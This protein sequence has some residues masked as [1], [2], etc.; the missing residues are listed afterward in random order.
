MKKRFSM[1]FGILAVLFISQSAWA[2]AGDKTTTTTYWANGDLNYINNGAFVRTA[3]NGFATFTIA[4]GDNDLSYTNTYHSGW[5]SREARLVF[6]KCE[7]SQQKNYMLTWTKQGTGFQFDATGVRMVIAQVGSA[8]RFALGDEDEVIT[9]NGAGSKASVAT[10]KMTNYKDGMKFY[11]RRGSWVGPLPAVGEYCLMT[12]FEVNYEIIPDAPTWTKASDNMDVTVDNVLGQKYYDLS[13]N[14]N[15]ANPA[16]AGTVKYELVSNNAEYVFWNGEHTGFY[17]LKPGTYKVKAYIEKVDN[18]Y[19][20]SAYST[21]FTITAAT[22][23]A[24]KKDAQVYFVFDNQLVDPEDALNKIYKVNLPYTSTDEH[25]IEYISATPE[26]VKITKKTEN[27]LTYLG[28]TEDL[29]DHFTLNHKS[30]QDTVYV[31]QNGITYRLVIVSTTMGTNHLPYTITETDQFTN[32]TIV[33]YTNK[34]T[35]NDAYNDIEFDEVGAFETEKTRTIEFA[36]TGI[37]DSIK[38]SYNTLADANR[39]NVRLK[40]S[41]ATTPGN[42]IELAQVTAPQSTTADKNCAYA[43]PANAKYVQVQYYNAQYKGWVRNFTITEKK[44]ITFPQDTLVIKGTHTPGGMATKSTSLNWYNV[45]D[46]LNWG[47]GMADAAKFAVQ[48]SKIP[49]ALDQY[50]ENIPYNV[51]YKLDEPGIHYASIM[52]WS[53]DKNDKGEF[54]TIAYYTVKGITAYGEKEIVVDN[55]L[56]EDTIPATPGEV[57]PNPFVVKDSAGNELPADLKDSV[58]YEYTV[59]P[60]ES[61]TIDKDGNITPNCVGVVR[62]IAALQPNSILPAAF[63]TIYL[64]VPEASKNVIKWALPKTINKGDILP[65]A[66]ASTEDEAEMTYEF[67]PATAVQAVTGGYEVLQAGAFQIV[68]KAA[69]TCAHFAINDTVDVYANGLVA[70]IELNS[71]VDPA[72][73]SVLDTIANMFVVKGENGDTLA[74]PEANITYAIEPASMHLDED[75][76]FI[77]DHCGNVKV[78]VTVTGD[79]LKTATKDFTFTLNPIAEKI[80]SN[81]PDTLLVGKT[82]DLKNDLTST[83]SKLGIDTV[84]VPESYENFFTI[85]GTTIETLKKGVVRIIMIAKGNADFIGPI[86]YTKEVTIV[87][88]VKDIDWEKELKEELENPQVGDTIPTSQVKVFDEDGHEITGVEKTYEIIPEGAAHVTPEGDVVV[89]L[90]IDPITVVVTTEKEGMETKVDTIIISAKPAS[91]GEVELPEDLLD[92]DVHVGDTISLKDVKVY[93]Q[94][95]KDIT[96]QMDK[97][98]F[99]IEPED[100]AHFEKVGKNDSVLVIDKDE[101]FQIITKIT[102]PM[103]DPEH[104]TDT[105]KVEVETYN[106]GEVVM[107]EDVQKGELQPGETINTDDIRVLDKDGKDITDLCDKT[108]TFVPADAAHI[109]NG[110]IVIDKA[111][112]IAI[113]THIE[114]EGIEPIDKTTQIHVDKFVPEDEGSFELPEPEHENGYQ[115]GDELPIVLKDKDGK[116]ITDFADI[117]VTIDPADKAHFDPEKNVIVL[118]QEGPADFTITVGGDNVEPYTYNE[119][120][121]IHHDEA[122]C[123]DLMVQLWNDVAIVNN[124]NETATFVNY[125]WYKNGQLVAGQNGQD[126]HE[127]NGAAMNGVYYAYAYDAAG[128]KYMICEQEFNGTASA[129]PVRELKVYPTMVNTSNLYTIETE[130]AGEV[131]IST[132]NGSAAQRFTVEAGKNNVHA[133]FAQGVY[134]LRFVANDGQS[135]MQ[136]LI[137]K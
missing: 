60:A 67:I 55:K 43:L 44:A 86:K 59:T 105:T 101:D 38:F 69:Q 35:W 120:I 81:I 82:Y 68:A 28:Q 52:F 121:Y 126:Y 1:F 39:N 87:G 51:Q 72:N 83:L 115:I 74:A 13:S 19:C 132:S 131:F 65:A 37:P 119:S 33:T 31:E 76:N 80:F 41:Y 114:G 45:K 133:P 6:S 79:T 4:G 104:A 137:V 15:V 53:Q 136:K 16:F 84:Y 42:W 102:D 71:T 25:W 127:A 58:K 47:I 111:G 117:N 12:A 9:D 109:E 50:K 20:S 56:P 17:V 106:V 124:N 23:E 135:A 26:A 112:D 75:G 40:I 2:A 57:I 29:K 64:D 103:V 107:P 36:Y 100:A 11:F 91:I 97:I 128:N 7:R 90:P 66:P 95:G 130:I 134:M 116:D 14:I 27:G 5:G 89:D 73:M 88:G 123:Y 77:V 46:S 70:S 49:T 78:T 92:G 129:A 21:E 125:E 32:S 22:A 110:E 30:A 61:A 48:S 118:D 108:Y 96:D 93:D 3:D 85:T 54:S 24:D 63:D 10:T 34:I 99:I 62:I 98:E 113:I 18:L 94:N 8:G 122:G